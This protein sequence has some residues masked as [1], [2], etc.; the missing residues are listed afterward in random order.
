M[1]PDL[2]ALQAAKDRLGTEHP[3]LQFLAEP[4]QGQ[5][6]RQMFLDVLPQADAESLYL[7]DPLG[8]WMMVYPGA[9][10]YKGILKDIK[11]LLRVSQI[12]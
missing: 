6:L 8:N 3:D 9:A 10:E 1:A 2:A 7:V 12:G 11:R 5:T 4:A